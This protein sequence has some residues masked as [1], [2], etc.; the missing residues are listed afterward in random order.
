M[1]AL[2]IALIGAENVA[3]ATRRPGVIAIGLGSLLALMAIASAAGFGSLPASLLA[4]AGLFGASYL[5]MSGHL[6]DAGRLRLVVTLVFGLIHGFGFAANL[7][8][9]KLP[10]ERLVELLVGFNLGVEVGQACGERSLQHLS[11]RSAVVRQAVAGR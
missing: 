8:E 4:G 7:L 2:T 5:M 11:L 3:V 9:M 1:V 10:Q 6:Y